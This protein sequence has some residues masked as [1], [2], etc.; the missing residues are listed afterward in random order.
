MAS[1][2]DLTTMEIVAA[3][4]QHAGLAL[5]PEERVQFAEHVATVWDL[6]EALRRVDSPGLEG[7][8]D[9]MPLRTAEANRPGSGRRRPQRRPHLGSPVAVDA[10]TMHAGILAIGAAV[11]SGA[12]RPIDVVAAF[13]E[14]IRAYD[15]LV[16]SYITVDAE[17][18]MAAAEEL[19]SEL[20]GVR[21]PRSV[22]H[23]VPYGVKDSIPA[24]ALPTT[25]NSPLMRAW[26]PAR[27]SEPI[28][29][30]RAAGAVLLGKHNLNEFE[31][32]LPGDADLAP[33]PRNP[34]LPTEASVGSSSGGAA[35]VSAGLA[36]F[37]LG[38]DGGGSTRLP[39]GQHRLFGLKPGHD[40]VPSTG[41]GG[42]SVSEV[43][44]L[45]RSAPDAA[46]V[47]AAMLID[48]DVPE[49]HE[50]YRAEPRRRAE[51][52]V[53]P[54]EAVRLGVPWSYIRDID[55]ELATL[56]VFDEACRACEDLGWELIDVPHRAASL[57]HDAVRANFVLIAAEHFF[58]HE[59]TIAHRDRY[60][61]SAR[62]YALPGCCLTASDY[63]HAKRVGRIARQAVD[64]V[65]GSVDALLTPTS[66]VTRTSSSRDPSTHRSGSNAAFTAAFNLTGHP[67][68]SA[69]AGASPE[70]LPIGVQLVG[71]PAGEFTLLRLAHAIAARLPQPAFPDLATMRDRLAAHHEPD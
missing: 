4:V 37:A 43:G 36:A 71:R 29:R 30:L 59:G 68:V 3:F 46:A 52:V 26:I 44:V 20:D 65:L 19:G 25:Y 69:P 53:L 54:A 22:L 41:V 33:P 32:S 11:D 14:R 56:A 27:D 45:A 15:P 8:R 49:A 38:T 6:A 66:R 40:A 28:R 60:G 47:L 5:A 57:L 10:A 50:R 61:D 67:A 48:P 23:G 18:A 1:S 39:A 34:F 63:L 35:A 17:G 62:F 13:L 55:V 2:R 42:P 31:W 64:A 58:D 12:C 51:E 9:Q 24:L 16:R 21:A 70:G 7:L